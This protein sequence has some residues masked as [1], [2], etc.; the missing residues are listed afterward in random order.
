MFLDKTCGDV[1]SVVLGPQERVVQSQVKC[2]SAF[3][4]RSLRFVNGKKSKQGDS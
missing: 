3:G 1:I 2:V 4:T